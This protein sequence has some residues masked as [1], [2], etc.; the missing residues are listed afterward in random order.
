MVWGCLVLTTLAVARLTRL[1]TADVI[2]L[3][4]RRWVINRA[5]EDSSLAYLVHCSWCT[6]IWLSFPL[7]A[8]WAILMLPMHLWWMLIPAALTMSYVTGLLSQIEE[9]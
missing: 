5:G 3:P 8:I 9:R 2:M 4:F 6:S 7:A 1:V